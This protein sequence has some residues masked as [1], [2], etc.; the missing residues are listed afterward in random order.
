[1]P[2]NW[3]ATRVEQRAGGGFPDLFMTVEGLPVL[4]ELKC[5]SRFGL[6]LRPAQIAFNY[7]MSVQ[8][9]MTFVLA[10]TPD[11]RKPVFWLIKGANIMNLAQD[12]RPENHV[13][14]LEGHDELFA[15]LRS[16]TLDHYSE[17]VAALRP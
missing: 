5:L 12:P 14:R 3:T 10:S 6:M 11:R 8:N 1:M 17:R 2:K 16:A 4:V 9:C 13:P 7:S 15:A